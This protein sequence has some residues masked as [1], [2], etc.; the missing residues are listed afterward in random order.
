L[1]ATGLA[2]ARDVVAAK[3]PAVIV[4]AMMVICS[5]PRVKVDASG[6]AWVTG[7]RLGR[8]KGE[9]LQRS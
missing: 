4:A 2:D 3:N 9:R 8:P 1:T 5:P 6:Q 7:Y